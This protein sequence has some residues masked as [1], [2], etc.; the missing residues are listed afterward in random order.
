MITFASISLFFLHI[1]SLILT[2]TFSCSS[3]SLSLSLWAGGSE[4][5]AVW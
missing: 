3:H 5:V 4:Q 2:H 1:L